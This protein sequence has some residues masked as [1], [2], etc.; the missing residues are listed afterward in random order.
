MT[1]NDKCVSNCIKKGE[2]VLHPFDLRLFSNE[3]YDKMCPTNILYQED[4]KIL[5]KGM[6]PNCK[7]PVSSESDLIDFMNK[8][9]VYVDEQYLLDEVF[10]VNDIDKFE[11]WID[12]NMDK[13]MLYINRVINIWIRSN[14]DDIV[15]SLEDSSV[16][17]DFFLNKI[18]LVLITKKREINNTSLEKIKKVLPKFI[19]AWFKKKSKSKNDFYF[20][21]LVDFNNYFD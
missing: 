10:E 7:N 14:F 4:T 1:D 18:Y 20:D 13:P 17:S 15:K 11:K 21:L 12:Q 8:P 3:F 16:K 6:K 2:S 9:Y 19:K 5:E